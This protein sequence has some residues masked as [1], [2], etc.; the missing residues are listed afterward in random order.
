M[1]DT[2][3]CA[4]HTGACFVLEIDGQPVTALEDRSK[5]AEYAKN[6]P[7][8]LKSDLDEARWSVPQPVGPNPELTFAVSS[9]GERWFGENPQPTVLVEPLQGQSLEALDRAPVNKAG[10]T[11]SKSAKIFAGGKLPPG[12]YLFV[13]TL[14]GAANWDRKNIFASVR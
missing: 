4:A 1:S 3:V 9:P 2:T 10:S 13:I 5:V 11:V 7:S 12:D 8:E 14:R 6:A